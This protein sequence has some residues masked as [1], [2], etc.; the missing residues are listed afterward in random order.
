MT[1]HVYT[2][3]DVLNAIARKETLSGW[4]LT[5]IDLAGANLEGGCFERVCLNEANLS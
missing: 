1:T 3:E 5:G 4:D 2:K